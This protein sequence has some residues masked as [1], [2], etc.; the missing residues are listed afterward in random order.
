[1]SQNYPTADDIW[2]QVGMELELQKQMSEASRER[3]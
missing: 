3:Q 2:H 1:M